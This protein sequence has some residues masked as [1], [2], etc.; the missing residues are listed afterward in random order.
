MSK[1]SFTPEQ[2]KAILERDKDILVAAAAGS[3]KTAVLVERI[4]SII[5][6]TNINV[7]VDKLLVVTFTEAAGREMKLRL[8]KKIQSLIEQNPQDRNLLRQQMLLSKAY[9]GTAHSFFKKLISE[10]FYILD[11][12]PN[13]RIGDSI[14]IE[15]M[16]DECLEI[17]LDNK[18]EQCKKEEDIVFYELIEMYGDKITDENF[19]EIILDV[20]NFS[21]NTTNPKRWLENISNFYDFNKDEN[22][23][24]IKG[25]N[26]IIDSID[27]KIQYALMYIQQALD[28]AQRSDYITAYVETLTDDYN[29][30]ENIISNKTKENLFEYYYEQLCNCEFGRMK[31]VRISK[32]TTEDEKIIIE[33]EK[34][35]VST[36][37]DYAK[38]AIRNITEEYFI[39]PP[40]YM[41]DD[42]RQMRKY[43]Q[44]L[45]EIVIEFMDLYN[46]MKR[47]QNIMD[48]NDLEQLTIKLLVNDDMTCTDTAKAY[49][50]L[51]YEIMID[52]YQDTNMVQELIFKSL[53]KESTGKNN[54]FMVGDVKQ[55]IYSF[56]RANPDLFIEKYNTF[57]DDNDKTIKIDLSKNFRSNNTVIDTVNFIFNQIMHN[58]TSKI[59]YVNGQQLYYGAD[60][61]YKD[62][63][64]TE[65]LISDVANGEEGVEIIDDKMELESK[66]IV[67]KIKE[68]VNNEVITVP[69]DITKRK[70][71][72]NKV[73]Y[74]N[75]KVKRIKNYVIKS[76]RMLRRPKYKDIVILLRSRTQIT[77]LIDELKLNNIPVY[78]KKTTGFFENIEIQ[79]I[80]SLLQVIDNPIQDIHYVT[81]L[82]SP[83]YW[84]DEDELVILKNVSR[85]D[86]MHDC[87][88]IFL[89]NQENKYT[90][91]NMYTI[92]EKLSDDL[93]YFREQQHNM[94]ISEFVWDIFNRTNYLSYIYAMENS[95]L[96]V[97]N[98]NMFIERAVSYEQ[99]SYVSIFNFIK[100]LDKIKKVEVDIGDAQ[101][102]SETENVIRI[103]TIHES[104]GLEFPIVFVSQL[105][106]EINRQD[107][108]KNIVITEN[109]P[110]A[111]KYF[112]TSTRV[113]SNTLSREIGVQT[114]KD[115]AV[116]EE[117]R[118][119]YV[120][121][122]RAKEK[123][124]LTGVTPNIGIKAYWELHRGSNDRIIEK[125]FI[126]NSR[127]ILDIVMQAVVRNKCADE[128]YEEPANNIYSDYNLP[129][130][131]KYVG[132][133]AD[134]Y[135]YDEVEEL[136]EINVSVDNDIYKN[137]DEMFEFEYKYSVNTM[138]KSSIAEIKRKTD[139]ELFDVKPN[140]IVYKKPNFIQ[141]NEKLDNLSKGTII[142][143]IFEHIPY[144]KKYDTV[145]FNEFILNLVETDIL[146]TE[147]LEI[148]NINKFVKYCNTDMFDRMIKSNNVYKEKMFVLGVKNSEINENVSEEDDNIVIISGIVD[149]FFEEND[150]NVLI[151]YKTDYVTDD[152]INDKVKDYT[153]Q[154]Q[155]Y[156]R[157][158][159]QATN[160][161]VKE[162]Y[163]YFFN[164]NKFVLVE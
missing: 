5:T 94:T 87:V 71:L 76:K 41:L 156:K 158:I 56:R 82:K 133:E 108:K 100:Y 144:N 26:V 118:I 136:D 17:L 153:P 61:V 152:T 73:D 9:I 60:Y 149:C 33:N 113:M 67:N 140:D 21:C 159:E 59:D 79:I 62:N 43:V 28:I 30:L 32:D 119:L 38:K 24:S 27:S 128:Y 125:E 42:M 2:M 114:I 84:L 93:T 121:L 13:F 104:K 117:L 115:E 63:G 131:I 45:S 46:D 37:R 95:E 163:I 138:T 15:M 12:D 72:K 78:A 1:V 10:N 103:M 4:I 47:S 34:E 49:Q 150:G 143:K 51:F 52:E 81:V 148:V 160:N 162:S 127:S 83:M 132:N 58:K 75:K 137:V 147:E 20:Y 120:A 54:R 110:F 126:S 97:A 74:S 122:T 107:Q 116:A 8:N 80:V 69:Y 64:Y 19:K 14:E 48:F 85:A 22:I 53:S 109:V 31:A 145:S 130:Q 7:D 141:K 98:I 65:I 6:D 90:Y 111:S 88:N 161:I 106:R 135:A 44:K 105:G 18:Y 151:D 86:S 101:Y 92:L 39:K 36:Y 11:I 68:L 29:M 157:A 146:T 89:Q 96:K 102:L 55:S 50:Q 3:G 155:V 35:R 77:P 123:L 40:H 25:I 124:I 154:I 164:I 142:H 70:T 23:D 134:L 91:E 57:S 129:I 16:K 99:T 66:I 112:N 139:V